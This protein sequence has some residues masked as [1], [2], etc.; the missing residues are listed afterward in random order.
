MRNLIK[1]FI[2]G[3]LWV[4]LNYSLSYSADIYNG[5]LIDAH[6]QKGK[7]ISVEAVADNINK[8]DVDLTLLSF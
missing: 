8:S 3:F 7:L 4:T 5:T 2:S 1:I 6:S